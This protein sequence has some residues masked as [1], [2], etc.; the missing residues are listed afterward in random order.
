MTCSY[1]GING[2]EVFKVWKGER[3]ESENTMGGKKAKHDK[4]NLFNLDNYL[5]LKH[6]K[7]ILPPHIIVSTLIKFMVKPIIH[8]R[9]RSTHLWYLEY[10]IIFIL[11]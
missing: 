9:G 10:S 8:V 1:E 4:Y 6:H 5:L 7:C 3:T 2:Y 11:I